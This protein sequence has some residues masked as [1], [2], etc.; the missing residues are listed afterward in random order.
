ML[1]EFDKIDPVTGKMLFKLEANNFA[2]KDGNSLQT[3]AKYFEN[4]Y[5]DRDDGNTP[6]GFWENLKSGGKLQ[7]DWEA[8]MIAKRNASKK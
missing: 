8:K 3:K 1:G 2:D 6:P 4:G 7:A 5:V